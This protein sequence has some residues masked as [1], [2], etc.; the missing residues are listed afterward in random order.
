VTVGTAISEPGEVMAVDPSAQTVSASA[1]LSAWEDQPRAAPSSAAPVLAIDGFAGPLDWLVEM[2]RSRKLDLARLSI[3]AL[4]EA[5]A[6]SMQAAFAQPLPGAR[7]DVAG[8][9]AGDAAGDAAAPLVPDL[10]RWA[11]WTVLAAQLTELRSRLLLPAE[12]PE[13][14]SAEADAETLRRTLV[15][16]AEVSAAAD[17][18]ER[19]PQL[20]QDVFARAAPQAGRGGGT[21]SRRTAAPDADRP[22]VGDIT[23]LL[24]ACLVAL[25]LP[26]GMSA[27]YQ[28]RPP[29][30]WTTGQAMRRILELLGKIVDG[31]PPCSRKLSAFLPGLPPD[32]PHRE[33]LC[34]GIVAGTFLAG[35]ELTRDGRVVLEQDQP[36]QTIGVRL[37]QP[38]GTT[39][40]DLPPVAAP[41][42][43]AMSPA[44]GSDSA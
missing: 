10:A 2:A 3:L 15:N 41:S 8:D 30:L 4:I 9:V 1:A 23:D 16:R 21:D 26:P 29:P 38:V 42:S 27:L 20:G 14:R 19:Q 11:G 6:A 44:A 22:I 43:A 32:A 7:G 28:P 5:F 40:A 13:A 18:L 37:A 34:R 33:L 36:W 39:A 17:W 25:R 24:R 31:A 12:S 35:L